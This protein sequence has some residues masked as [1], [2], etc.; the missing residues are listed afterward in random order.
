MAIPAVY[1]ADAQ[2]FPTQYAQKIENMIASQQGDNVVVTAAAND[3]LV[4]IAIGLRDAQRFD[5]F[6]AGYAVGTG[7]AAGYFRAFPDTINANPTIS[8][9]HN[10]YALITNVNMAES[11]YTPSATPPTA[12]NPYPSSQWSLD[13]YY[14]SM[15]IWTAPVATAGTYT[16][17]LNSCF[18]DPT[19]G[20]DLSAI[21][22]AAG[23]PIFKGGVTFLV[24]RFSGVLQSSPQDG[25][26]IGISSAAKAAPLPFTTTQGSELLL[27]AGL[28]KSGNVFSAGKV[29][30]GGSDT[31]DAVSLIASGKLVGSEGHYMI[32]MATPAAGSATTKLYFSNPL[33]YQML[34]GTIA[35]KHS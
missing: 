20:S 22:Q 7:T 32:E 11:D 33:G 28:M 14:P 23:R 13:G 24:I 5:D 27:A 18:H 21:A 1:A 16:V 9:G 3:T 29:N 4:A 12:P 17:N 15:Y 34:V 31:A 25:H 10:T 8:D 19:S 30:Q 26:A 2:G 35:L 6:H